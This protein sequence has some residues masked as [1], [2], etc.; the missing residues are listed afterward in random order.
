[1]LRSREGGVGTIVSD[2]S[3]RYLVRVLQGPCAVCVMSHTMCQW[4]SD[5]EH[6]NG[7]RKIAEEFCGVSSG[8]KLLL[9]KRTS[10]RNSIYFTF[11]IIRDMT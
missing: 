11:L 10:E 3:V 8:E 5:F 7:I 2:M 9:G 1:M 6:E 4:H